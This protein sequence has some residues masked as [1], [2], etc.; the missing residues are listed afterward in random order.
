MLVMGWGGECMATTKL[1]PWLRREIHRQGSQS[2]GIINE[3][4][5][6]DNILLE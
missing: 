5:Q 1:A 2:L 4:P 6:R 3:D